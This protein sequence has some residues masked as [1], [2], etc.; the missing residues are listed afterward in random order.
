MKNIEQHNSKAR[1]RNLLDPKNT[2][3]DGGGCAGA[4]GHPAGS[5]TRCACTHDQGGPADLPVRPKLGS[6]ADRCS[7]SYKEHLR[8]YRG[9]RR[10]P[11][12][13]DTSF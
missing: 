5:L 1:S 2:K 8:N 4:L 6:I 3:R 7:T 10:H 9:G 13:D 12:T 11:W